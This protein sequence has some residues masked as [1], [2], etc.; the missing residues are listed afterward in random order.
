MITLQELQ[1]LFASA[2]HQ[3]INPSFDEFPVYVATDVIDENQ[4]V[5]WNRIEIQ[6]RMEAREAEIERLKE[7]RSAMYQDAHNRVLEYIIQQTK[8]PMNK[9][10]ILWNFIITNFG[11]QGPV[12]WQHLENQIALYNQLK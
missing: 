7:I 9:A 11:G 12:L 4:S 6:K 3:S 8:M 1:T 10:E 5:K 2:D